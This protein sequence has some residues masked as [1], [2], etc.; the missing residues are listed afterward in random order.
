MKYVLDACVALRWVL[1]EQDSDKAGRVR[2]DG[3]NRRHDLIAPE[4]FSLECAHSLTKQQRRGLIPEA[5]FL[6][7]EIMLDAPAFFTI[8]PLMDRALELSI[9]ARHNIYDCL[10]V[11]LAE[12]E[13]C[14]VLTA[15]ERMKR[16]LPGSPIMLLSSLP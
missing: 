14:M 15:D 5:R 10:Y 4:V 12:R 2:L 11:A 6:W 3:Q 8:M 9:E 13:G 16:N 1:I 7:E